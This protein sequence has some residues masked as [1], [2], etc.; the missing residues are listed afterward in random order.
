ML[1]FNKSDVTILDVGGTIKY[2]KTLY[3]E[4]ETNTR[5][6]LLNVFSQNTSDDFACLQGTATD[7]PQFCDNQFDIVFSNSVIEHVGS[8]EEQKKM[9]NEV[10]RIGKSYWIQTPNRYFPIEPHFC[11]PLFIFLPRS[12]QV[13]ILTHFKSAYLPKSKDKQAAEIRIDEIRLLSEKELRS[14]F[15]D[16]TIKRERFLGLTKSLIAYKI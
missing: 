2:W 5:I 11:F 4:K 3:P 1:M 9:S 15:P 16:A 12:V 7:M 8:F 10:R 6:S 14:L 13:F